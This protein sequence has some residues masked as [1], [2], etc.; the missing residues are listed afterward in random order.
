M[1]KSN[2][3]IATDSY[4]LTIEIFLILYILRGGLYHECMLVRSDTD[5]YS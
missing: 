5:M 1:F 2:Y 4:P 3:F